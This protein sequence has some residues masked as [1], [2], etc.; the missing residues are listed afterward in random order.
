M[1]DSALPGSPALPKS[2]LVILRGKSSER[3]ELSHFPS[4]AP[5]THASVEDSGLPNSTQDQ[6][7]D[8]QHFPSPPK[9]G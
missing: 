7:L 4:P 6:G 5:S 8:A 3:A 9:A 1:E 2:A